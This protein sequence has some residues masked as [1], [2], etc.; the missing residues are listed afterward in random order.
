MYKG[1]QT[2]TVNQI[3]NRLKVNSCVTELMCLI[4]NEVLIHAGKRIS[5][6]TI[7]LYYH[8]PFSNIGEEVDFTDKLDMKLSDKY[9]NFNNFKGERVEKKKKKKKKS[10][11][12]RLKTIK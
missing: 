1:F 12:R 7:K 2:R 9:Y 6:C 10:N 4:L 3:I 8:D 11:I 5:F